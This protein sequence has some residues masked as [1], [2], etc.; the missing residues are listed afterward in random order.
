MSTSTKFNGFANS[1][2]GT[3]R[4]YLDSSQKK[5]NGDLSAGTSGINT[6]SSGSSSAATYYTN[7]LAEAKKTGN[8]GLATWAQ[9]QLVNNPITAKGS[10][11]MG[12]GGASGGTTSNPTGS[13]MTAGGGTSVVGML[14]A[15]S[16][17]VSN[18]NG[19]G[20]SGNAGSNQGQGGT[21]VAPEYREDAQKLITQLS[22]LYNSP[23]QYDYTTDPSYIAAQQ[24]ANDA[25]AGAKDQ[26]YADMADRGILS[27]S[28][29]SQQLNTIENKS[30]QSVLQLI[31]GLEAN[32]YNRHQQSVNNQAH[33]IE[34]ALGQLN[35]QAG[36]DQ[37]ERFHKDDQS[38]KEA[39]TTGTYESPEYKALFDTLLGAKTGWHTAQTQAEKD[40][41][42][43]QG[44]N[45]RSALAALTGRSPAEIEKLF[46]GGVTAEQ[47]LANYGMGGAETMTS[48]RFGVED[49]RYADET[50]YK[51]DQD[52]KA[53][54]WKQ[55]EY[56][57]EDRRIAKSGSGGS[58]GPSA[59]EVNRML[60]QNT[61]KMIYSMLKGGVKDEATAMEWINKHE[62][63]VFSGMVNSDDLLSYFTKKGESAAKDGSDGPTD[64]QLWNDAEDLAQKDPRVKAAETSAYAKPLTQAEYDAIVQ[65]KHDILV[66]RAGRGGSSYA[67]T[68]EQQA[69]NDL[70]KT[71]WLYSLPN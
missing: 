58:R 17:L 69:A 40:G 21:T 1:L 22:G 61:S 54:D 39:D 13:K 50:K 42:V 31:P 10:P 60:S 48:K 27:S 38:W 56:D 6:T 29:T 71:K 64:Y 36:Y 55:K 34:T 66:K 18:G 26:T 15:V 67:M 62:Q 19:G 7:K 44:A 46:G 43:Q 3:Q 68:P 11:Q 30:K 51:K 49:T 2:N 20:T 52:K 9:A 8:K 25:A 45:A 63:D 4:P 24:A 37:T 16:P 41:F 23:F 12:G 14:G 65:E 35:W 59:S 28:V 47:A 57:Q 70:H 33:A 53:W 32:A 5:K